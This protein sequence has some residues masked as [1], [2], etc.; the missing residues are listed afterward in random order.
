MLISK[1]HKFIF[2]HLPKNAGSSI[3]KGLRKYSD[4]P[5]ERLY[6]YMIDYLGT[7]PFLNLYPLHISPRELK[8]KIRSVENFNNYFKFAFVRNP[9]DWHVSQFMYHKQ[10]SN[11]FFN[12][13]FKQF[14]FDDYVEWA[15]KEENI[16]LAKSRQKE[17]LSDRNGEVIVDYIG[18]YETLHKDYE[19]ICDKIGVGDS[20]RKVN[21][22]KRK[23]SYKE[24]YNSQTKQLIFEAF[25]EDINYFGYE[26]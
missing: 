18:K 10:A 2:F 14:T 12:K 17:F 26:F 6:Y 24:Y 11:A 1:K 4:Y 20:L 21:L 7:V 8:S 25:K 13:T 3:T 23:K 15:V 9:W 5:I 16:I 19:E 22:S